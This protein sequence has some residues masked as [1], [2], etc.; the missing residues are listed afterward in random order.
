MKFDLVRPL[1]R[2]FYLGLLLGLCLGLIAACGAP[3]PS[4]NAAEA[5]NVATPERVNPVPHTDRIAFSWDPVPAA[6]SYNVYAATNKDILEAHPDFFLANV[7]T[8]YFVHSELEEGLTFHYLITSVRG[9][10]ESPAT[11]IYTVTT[12]LP[13]PF[14]VPR[15]VQAIAGDG[16]VFLWW[17]PIAD[18][19][20]YQVRGAQLTGEQALSLGAAPAVTLPARQNAYI[21]KGLVNGEQHA[22]SISALYAEGVSASS[23]LCCVIPEEAQPI[24]QRWAEEVDGFVNLTV[25]W[26]TPEDMRADSQ[27]LLWSTE[28]GVDPGTYQGEIA[29]SIKDERATHLGVSPEVN[30][31]YAVYAKLDDMYFKVAGETNLYN[32][33]KIPC[34]HRQDRLQYRRRCDDPHLERERHRQRL[35]RLRTQDRAYLLAY[36]AAASGHA[37][38]TRQHQLDP[39]QRDAEPGLSL[40]RSGLHPGR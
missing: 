18:A 22:Y 21:H 40:R 13:D 24:R 23:R 2:G 19:T 1:A 10:V 16:E 31:Y 34:P 27:I 5:E 35:L 12:L 17:E 20:G 26:S 3:V 8:P 36:R 4:E 15:N 29:L 38:G 14:P 33:L 25:E 11:S 6:D 32:T 9:V 7:E 30:Y 39:P 28:P 37:V